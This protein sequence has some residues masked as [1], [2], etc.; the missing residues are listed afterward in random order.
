MKL[1]QVVNH[2]QI[3]FLL[4]ITLQM[5]S[6]IPPVASPP[7][8]GGHYHGNES[9]TT[10]TPSRFGGGLQV[11]SATR[12]RHVAKHKDALLMKR[13]NQTSTQKQNNKTKTTMFEQHKS[14]EK[15]EALDRAN[16]TQKYADEKMF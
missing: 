12:R 3:T 13:I 7:Y 1:K 15:V 14:E 16:L 9:V 11:T 6:T 10:T 5:D 2:F 4:L 8:R